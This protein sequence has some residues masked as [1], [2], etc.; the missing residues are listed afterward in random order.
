MLSY[1]CTPSSCLGD[2]Y[3]CWAHRMSLLAKVAGGWRQSLIESLPRMP[4]GG[5]CL[6]QLLQNMPGMVQRP[7]DSQKGEYW[8]LD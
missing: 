7:E 8:E 1:T 2:L 3:R 4:L 6:Q 5:R